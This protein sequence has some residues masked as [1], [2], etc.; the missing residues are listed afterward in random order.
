MDILKWNEIHD[1]Q[2]ETDEVNDYVEKYA[3]TQVNGKLFITFKNINKFV[4]PHLT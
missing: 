2:F 1:Q 4:L 3:H